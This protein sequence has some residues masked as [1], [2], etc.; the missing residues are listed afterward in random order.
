MN[1]SPMQKKLEW[2]FKKY[3]NNSSTINNNNLWN[4]LN[5]NSKDE[6]STDIN[7]FKNIIADCKIKTNIP[8]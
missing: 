7:K 5:G 4:K 6:L 8:S 3:K 1:S 2:F